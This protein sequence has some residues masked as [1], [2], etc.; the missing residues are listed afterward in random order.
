[1][2]HQLKLFTAGPV[3]CFPEVL[4]VMSSQMFSHRSPEYQE[5]HS[6]T[7]EL[8]KEFLETKQTVLLVPSSGTGL[9]EASI[10][11][12]VSPNGKVLVTVIGEFGERYAKVVESNGRTAIR[13]KFD[14]GDPV[15]EEKLKE[16]LDK[17]QDVEA[18][19]ITHNETSTGVLNDLPRLA[20]IVHKYG[21]L[22]FV[23][24]VS[25]CG[26]TE[27]KFD[28]WKIDFLFTSS[29]KALGIPPGL[30]F[31][32]V[33]D[34]VLEVAEKIP[35][36]GYYFDLL[37]YVK[38]QK[39]RKSTPTTPP[40]PQIMGLNVMLKKIKSMGKENW[41][42][43]YKR[44]AEKIRKGVLDM[45][46]RLLAKPGY[47]SPT[48]TC[49][50]TPEGVGPKIYEKMRDRGFELAAGYGELKN[51]SFRIGHMGYILDEDIDA[52]LNTLESVLR[53][54]NVI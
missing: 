21:K 45:G 15:N 54:L 41:F 31:C 3:A 40:I 29:Q 48:I 25:S 36:R 47:E 14:L 6:E 35:N 10:R 39:E 44:R 34:K 20:Q 5:L 1:M 26:G 13:L 7:V 23:D 19:T 12:A 46:L 53:E 49:V 30:A 27:I 33:S 51:R 16:A 2:K 9:M 38:E 37:L 28:E 8:L 32:A 52:M 4:Q 24:A 22:C 43:I 50:L 17:Y 18:V 11:N 42:H